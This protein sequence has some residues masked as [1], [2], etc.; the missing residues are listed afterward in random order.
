MTLLAIETAT[1]TV[2]V[3]L[4]RD[5]GGVT[6]RVHAGGRAHAELLA[7]SIEEVCATAG[8]TVRDLD[9]IAVDIGPGLFTG[10]RVGVA[11]AK[12]LAQALGIG[13][14]GVTSLDVL[15]AAALDADRDRRDAD[16]G[17]SGLLGATASVVDA[18]RGEV[19]AALY[20]FDRAPSAATSAGPVD[21]GTV[22]EDRMEPLSPEAL[23]EWL[24]AVAEE[25]GT[26]SVLGDGAVRY[27]ALL[28]E[29]R[30]LDLSLADAGLAAPP[31]LALVGLARR[32]LDAGVATLSPGEVA[33]EYRRP[34]DAQINWE[35]RP[36][37]PAVASPAST[38]ESR[39]G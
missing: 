9:A 19:F 8:C 35:Q 21:P 32:R 23:V 22:R 24:L 11:T 36:T 10:L 17:A 13:V 14:L 16:P 28:A 30:V 26:V 39:P 31:A 38:E 6:E 20:R 29:H 18:R 12:A 5:D 2:A 33:P 34:A 7:P 3:A 4:L 37:R 1:D 25:A 15:A 27:R